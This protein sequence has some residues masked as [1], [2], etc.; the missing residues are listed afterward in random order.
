[1]VTLTGWLFP[2]ESKATETPL[3]AQL[4][5]SKNTDNLVIY[6]PYPSEFKKKIKVAGISRTGKFAPGYCTDYVSKK[7]QVSWRGNANVWAKNAKALGKLVDKM[8]QVG[9]I[10]QTNES[11]IGHVAYIESVV[12][13]TM[14]ISEWNYAGRY[15]QT[16]RTLSVNDSRVVAIIHP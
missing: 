7:V 6:R 16:V 10:V 1:M 5:F 2:Y 13:D 12:G 3:K 9:A 4:I 15:K 14:T 8:P 11:R